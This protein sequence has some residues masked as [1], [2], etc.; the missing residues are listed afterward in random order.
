VAKKKKAKLQKNIGP[1]L[2]PN[3]SEEEYWNL[4]RYLMKQQSR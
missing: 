1:N 3:N 4:E 2:N